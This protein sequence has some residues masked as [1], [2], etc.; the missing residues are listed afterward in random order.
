MFTMH[1]VVLL[2]RHSLLST[3]PIM[4]MTTVMF[5]I[6]SNNNKPQS[7]RRQSCLPLL[8][9]RNNSGLSTAHSGWVY[10]KTAVS[11]SS[12]GRG[13]SRTTSPRISEQPE[14]ESQKVIINGDLL[15]LAAF[16]F[17]KVFLW[18]SGRSLCCGFN[19]QG[20]HI[21]IKKMYS[22]NVSHFG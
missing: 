3:F 17:N 1:N 12:R 18:L 2:Q 10:V 15:Q 19:S 21:M 11:V 6:T 14:S 16:S 9:N 5:I 22:V 13:L 4:C 8:Q 20:T 7:L